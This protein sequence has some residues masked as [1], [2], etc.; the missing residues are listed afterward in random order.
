MKYKWVYL[1][2]VDP[3][4]EARR[5]IMGYL[6]WYHRARTHSRI[7]KQTPDEAYAVMLPTVELAA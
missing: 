6:D 4:S 5:W 1:H 3:V 2:A 7:K